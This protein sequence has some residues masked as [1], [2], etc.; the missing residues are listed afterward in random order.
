MLQ[1][2]GWGDIA[3]AHA[4]GREEERKSWRAVTVPMLESLEAWDDRGP[5]GEGWQ[6][7]ELMALINAIRA[8]GGGGEGRA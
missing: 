1:E 6:S 7:A 8:L 2:C 3:T 4:R 5:H